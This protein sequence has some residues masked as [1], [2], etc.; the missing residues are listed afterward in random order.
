MYLCTIIQWRAEE[1]KTMIV[2]EQA[3]YDLNEKL[4]YRNSHV[5]KKSFCFFWLSWDEHRASL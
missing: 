2:L 1:R 4:I 3:E 5:C